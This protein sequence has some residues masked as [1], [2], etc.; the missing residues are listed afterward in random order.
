M[1]IIIK[2]RVDIGTQMD[3]DKTRKCFA[4]GEKQGVKI[5]PLHFGSK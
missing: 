5:K 1:R 2:G 3:D 4:E